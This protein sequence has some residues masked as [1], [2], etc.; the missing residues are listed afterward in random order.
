MQSKCSYATHVSSIT[1]QSCAVLFAKQSH[2]FVAYS[3]VFIYN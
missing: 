1:C 3:E 2:S